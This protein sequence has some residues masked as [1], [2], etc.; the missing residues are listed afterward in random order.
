MSEK[1]MLKKLMFCL[2]ISSFIWANIVSAALPDDMQIAHKIL[3]QWDKPDEPLRV[4]PIVIVKDHAIAGW[5]QGSRGGRALLR[6][7]TDSWEVYLCGGSDLTK[8]QLLSQAGMDYATA[9]ELAT[10]LAA[11]EQN[12]TSAQREQ[13][14]Q[15]GETIRVEPDQKHEHHHP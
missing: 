3:M 4:G 10:A 2:A 7:N 11:S 6:R 13:F 14:S 15:F 12:L 5:V 8:P 9:T 1:N